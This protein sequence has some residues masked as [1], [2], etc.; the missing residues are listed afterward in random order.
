[1]AESPA[2]TRDLAAQDRPLT[3]S[4]AS[5]APHDAVT[6]LGHSTV[7]VDVSGARLLTDP[8][9]RGRLG[10]L[11]R[12]SAPIPPHAYEQID[13]VL[14]SHLHLDH[15]DIPSLRRLPGDVPIVVPRGGGGLLRRHGLRRVCEV[16]VGETVELARSQVTA[17][18]AVHPGRRRAGPG[19][20]EADALGFLVASS[21]SRI[22]FAGDTDLHPGME[23]LAPVDVALL[24]VWGWGPGIGAGHMDPEA[25]AR[26]A[27]LLRP[28]IAVPIHWG[29]LFPVGLAWA[30]PGRLTEPPREFAR[31]AARLAPEVEV[32]ILEP[33]ASLDLRK[34]ATRTCPASW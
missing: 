11:R 4:R 17:V 18:P 27:A 15:L 28:R 10:H 20:A 7:R 9:L 26:A 21:A 34:G 25:A 14:I 5:M 3:P 1:M 30:H 29:T 23:A 8:V 31:H 32:R 12:R 22:Y 24:P 6:F 19:A 16:V 33:G 13:G 2:P